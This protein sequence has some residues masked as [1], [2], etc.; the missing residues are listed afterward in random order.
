MF[1]YFI[2]M[3]TGY[4]KNIKSLNYKFGAN[5]IHWFQIYFCNKILKENKNKCRI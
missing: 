2:I 4:V 3:F 5:N 1:K